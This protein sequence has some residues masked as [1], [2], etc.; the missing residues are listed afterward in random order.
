LGSKSSIKV[1][2]GDVFVLET[3]GGGGWGNVDFDNYNQTSETEK[4]II[5][6][7]DSKIML[8]NQQKGSLNTYSSIQQSC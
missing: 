6:T 3:P 8:I 1:E 2:P 4:N 7:N 5:K